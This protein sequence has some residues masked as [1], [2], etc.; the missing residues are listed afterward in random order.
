MTH[1]YTGPPIAA[2]LLQEERARSA[3]LEAENV[4]WRALVVKAQSLNIALGQEILALKA[5]V[6]E[7]EAH[8]RER[9]QDQVDGW[10]VK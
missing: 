6:Q 5:R 8:V 3:C 2:L 9:E 10:S 1:G 4:K 7:L